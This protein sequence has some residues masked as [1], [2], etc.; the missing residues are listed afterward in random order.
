MVILF[1]ELMFL[2]SLG[3]REPYFSS[4]YKEEPI[5]PSYLLKW[6]TSEEI[7]PALTHLPLYNELMPTTSPWEVPEEKIVPGYFE[8]I[9]DKCF[10][11]D[12]KSTLSKASLNIYLDPGLGVIPHI[13]T[14]IYFEII[15]DELSSLLFKVNCFLSC[16]FFLL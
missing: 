9:A 10:Y 3:E 4:K 2:F 15:K 1:T 7:D 13:I 6:E 16:F 12:N 11:E 8:R 5:H 14:R